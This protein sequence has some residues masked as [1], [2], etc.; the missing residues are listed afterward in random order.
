MGFH[1][2]LIDR[3]DTYVRDVTRCIARYEAF[4]QLALG[5]VGVDRIAV[6][7]GS[8]ETGRVDVQY[9]AR[10]EIDTLV[11][12]FDVPVVE[13]EREFLRQIPHEAGAI[14]YRGF[15]FQ[16]RVFT[17]GDVPQTIIVR[18]GV[19]L[20]V[21]VG[22]GQIEAGLAA[23]VFVGEGAVGRYRPAIDPHQVGR[24]KTRLTTGA[25]QQAVD[26]PPFQLG[27]PGKVTADLRDVLVLVVARGKIGSQGRPDGDAEL[28]TRRIAIARAAPPRGVVVERVV[29]SVVVVARANIWTQEV[30]RMLAFQHDRHFHIAGRQREQTASEHELPRNGL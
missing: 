7:I 23:Q 27:S 5:R 8:Q 1:T 9:V 10:A 17:A 3:L 20:L 21:V 24:E 13:A 18:A 16:M 11:L 15:R 6:V 29:G 25:E 22:V 28:H 12:Q 19:A 14:G 2:G 30:L 4:V 26:R